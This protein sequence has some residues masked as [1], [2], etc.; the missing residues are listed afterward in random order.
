MQSAGDAP[1]PYAGLLVVE[2]SIAVAG[3]YA[4]M[5]LGDLG[6]E[7]IKVEPPAGDESR[8]WHPA[9]AVGDDGCYFLSVN[10]SK[11]S[12]QVDIKTVEGQEL[13]DRV[14]S[15]ADVL[16]VNFRPRALEKLGLSVAN[17]R[18]RYPRLIYA[19]VTGF[20]L[21]GAQANHP[22]M[23]LLI[24]AQ[25]GLMS[26]TGAVAGEPAKVPI[27][28]VDLAAALFAL[29][30]IQCAIRDRDRTGEGAH[31]DVSLQDS[32][33]AFLLYQ[34]T[35]YLE[36]GVQ[37]RR[38]GTEHPG[39]VPY[40]SFDSSDGQLVLAVFTDRQFVAACRVIG[41][42][43]VATD[44]RYTRVDQRVESREGIDR[45]FSAAFVTRGTEYWVEAMTDADV[46]CT[47]IRTVGDVAEDP[48]V[49]MK[50]AIA[51]MSRM[52]DGPPLR[53]PASPLIINGDRVQPMC[54]PPRMG[55]DAEQL[56]ERFGYVP[57]T[58]DSLGRPQ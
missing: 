46:P 50:G 23:D 6:A 44:V 57:K 28:V 25:T 47:P 42:E 20:G 49:L 58:T 45:I 54:L 1:R 55:A 22:A 29:T 30:G 4:A 11:L 13:L 37:P 53:M 26:I 27:P 52:P 9:A 38:M 15:S 39:I 12:V 24:Q 31:I 56:F 8:H 18:S 32:L 16:I 43:D 19:T 3:A 41:R 48:N 5:M 10:R 7:V 51:T 36:T 2:I 14:L 40:R 21:S 35:G 34:M 33:I 17:V